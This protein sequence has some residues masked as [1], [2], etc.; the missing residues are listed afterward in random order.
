MTGLRD[1]KKQQTRRHI[2]DV[3]ARLFAANGFDNVTVDEVAQAAE[4]SRK[5]VF[6]YF[7]TK[8]DLV[9]D[10]ED[11]R[12]E[13]LIELVRARPPGMSLVEA[14]RQDMVRFVRFLGT[15]EP[16]FQH[17]GFTGLMRSSPSLQRRG[18]QM[19]GRQER[20]VAEAIAQLMSTPEWDP[21][22]GTVARALLGA[23]RSVMVDCHRRLDDDQHPADVAA[24]L[25]PE[26]DRV[27]TLLDHG[28]PSLS[29]PLVDGAA[30]VPA[31][32]VVAWHLDPG[33]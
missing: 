1:Q 15:K 19:L 4:V 26:I 30:Q 31:G 33:R 7:P 29:P 23:C 27:F 16:G 25:E 5:T 6:N 24:A 28:L 21:V 14:F 20:C 8:E 11:E 17:G 13:R 32:P 2:A 22:A 12:E 9:F 10:L 18:Q 3:A